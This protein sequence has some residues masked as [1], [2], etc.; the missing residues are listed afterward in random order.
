VDE[1][2]RLDSERGIYHIGVTLIGDSST[3]S[4]WEAERIVTCTEQFGRW[5][6]ISIFN[7]SLISFIDLFQRSFG[8]LA[9][10]SW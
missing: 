6:T 2:K 9:A 4:E 8:A 3:R 10:S 1:V 7:S 5:L